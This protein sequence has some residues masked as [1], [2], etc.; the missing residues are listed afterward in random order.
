MKFNWGT[1]IALVYAL[2]AVGMV[3]MVFAAQRQDPVLVAKN[4]YDLDLNY[5]ARMVEKENASALAKPLEI[6]YLREQQQL[7]LQFPTDAGQPTGG[8]VK[9]FRNTTAGD[10]FSTPVRPDAAG[11]MLVPTAQFAAGRWQLEVQWKVGEKTFFHE[12]KLTL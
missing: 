8:T 11:Q 7:V 9:L 6:K 2:F 1:G 12:T 3:G 5:Q 4:Y 10:D